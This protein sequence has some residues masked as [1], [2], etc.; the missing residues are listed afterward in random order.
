MKK[1]TKFLTVAALLATGFSGTAMADEGF[2]IG[3][4]VVSSYVWRGTELGDSFAVQ[5][6]LTY[7]FAGSGVEVGAWG[8]YAVAENDGSR[9][10]EIDLYVSVPVGPL[11]LTA[12]DYFTAA[13]GNKSFDFT[14]DG[15]NVVEISASY[16]IDDLSLLAGVNV[17]GF[18]TNNAVYCEAGY[19]FY[20]K[21]G[22]TASGFVGAGNE[23]YTTDAD[24]N[25]VNTGISVS[26]DRYTASYVYNP[27]SE[28]SHLVF[29]ASF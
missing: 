2:S 12:T 3:A 19:Q 28:M 29:M 23:V 10:K 20:D 14:D 15:P 4:D 8:S 6:S 7:T 18:D 26:K 21:D 24:F 25:V 27:D 13:D 17:A 11:T 16:A 1:T 22:Y 9:Y 5:P